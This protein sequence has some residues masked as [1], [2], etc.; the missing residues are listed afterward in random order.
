[1]KKLVLVPAIAATMLLLA[2][3]DDESAAARVCL[4]DHGVRVDDQNCNTRTA[5]YNPWLYR[6]Y[7]MTRGSYAPAVGRP[8]F[9]GS[10]AASPSE[11]YVPASSGGGVVRGGFGATSEAH[12]FGGFGE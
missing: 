12:G 3:C 11:T 1:M 2:G 4:N 8:A 5:G 6:W 10:Y 9:G 7:Y